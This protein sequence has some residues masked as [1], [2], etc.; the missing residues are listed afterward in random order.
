MNSVGLSVTIISRDEED[1]IGD[2]IQSVA[3]ADEVVVLDSGSRDGTVALCQSLGARIVETDWPGHVAQKNRALEYATHDWVLSIDADER[4]TPELKNSIQKILSGNPPVDGYSVARRQRYLGRWIRFCGWYP[5]RRVR[6]FRRS[7]CRWGG[8]DPHD[9]IEVNGPV[10]SLSGDLL[11]LPY[12]DLS[13][14]IATIDRY[15]SIFAREAHARGRR[16]RWWDLVF[17][18]PLFFARRYFLS[19]GFLD[20]IHGVL[21]CGM[22]AFY[23]LCRWM[24]L[25]ELQR[26]LNRNP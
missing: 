23:V 13:D 22:G 25:F 9:R 14:H 16:A 18:P 10:R 6:L 3:F 12:R 17:R 21:V 7:R 8:I 24:K 2:A 1:R 19:L 20:G 26:E 15:S 11:H 5:D 4:V